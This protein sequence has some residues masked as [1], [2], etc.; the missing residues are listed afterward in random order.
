MGDRNILGQIQRIGKSLMLP[1][2]VLPAAALLLRLG[3]EDLLDIAFISQAGDA[4]FANLPLLFAIGV[5]VGFSHDSSG[6]AG[7]AGVVGYLVLTESAEAIDPEINMDVLG[8]IVAGLLAGYLYNKYYNIKLPEYLGFFGGKRF[9]PIVTGGVCVLLGGAMGVIWPPIQNVIEL[10]GEWIVGAGA[11]GVFIYGTLNRLLIPLGLHHII[12]SFIWFV[13]GEYEDPETGEV[14]MGEI[15]RFFAQDPEAGFFLAGFFAIM[16]FALPGVAYAMYKTA[17]PQ[18]KAAVGGALFSVAFT[19]FLTGITEPV[20]FAFM[21]LAP[22]LYILHALLTGAA[23]VVAQVLGIRHG[24]G[25]S[26]GFIDYLLNYGIAERPLLLIPV[27]I[28]FFLIYYLLFRFIIVKFNLPTPG[29]AGAV[30]GSDMSVMPEAQK[31][32]KEEEADLDEDLDAQKFIKN[33]GGADNIQSL[34]ACITRLRVTLADVEAIDEDG[35]KEM[36]ATGVMKLGS[37]N[38]QV[39]VGTRA[40]SIADR[41]NAEL[42]RMR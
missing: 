4:L 29:R 33:L 31:Q 42:E 26:A 40:E 9:V 18:N 7:L 22:L 21:F 28:V 6:S 34:E 11:L 39:V 32:A 37:K 24:F 1:I 41:I 36:G 38:I 23:M 14:V 27:G 17:E 12:N 13:F 15:E 8:G 35:L 10:T 20:E 2:A 5:A 30:A 19:S 25:F 16:M 3:A